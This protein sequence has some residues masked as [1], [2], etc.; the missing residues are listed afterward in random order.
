MGYMGLNMSLILYPKFAFRHIYSGVVA[1][2]LTA[3][4]ASIWPAAV[5]AR[6]EPVEAMRS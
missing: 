2:T 3:V 6:L 5:V 4:L 1:V